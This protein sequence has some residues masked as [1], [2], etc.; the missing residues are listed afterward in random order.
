M[1]GWG[2]K[3]IKFPKLDLQSWLHIQEGA[4]HARLSRR[5]KSHLA[6][7]TGRCLPLHGAHG[8]A[9]ATTMATAMAMPAELAQGML[10]CRESKQAGWHLSTQKKTTW[11]GATSTPGAR[12]H[13]YWKIIQ[14]KNCFRS[15]KLIVFALK[16]EYLGFPFFF[17][18]L[19]LCKSLPIDM[20]VCVYIYKYETLFLY[21]YKKEAYFQLLACPEKKAAEFYLGSIRMKS[22]EPQEPSSPRPQP[23]APLPPPDSPGRGFTVH[24]K[25]QYP[26][27]CP[28]L[29]PS[30]K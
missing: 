24:F 30:P 16:C 21:L 13:L 3:N 20:H 9:V 10:P 14:K 6:A 2:Q 28:S 19:S 5:C 27:L 4:R 7:P 25:N 18:K 26:P 11:E 23:R 17:S 15:N 8:H 12:G 22:F 29:F 1:S